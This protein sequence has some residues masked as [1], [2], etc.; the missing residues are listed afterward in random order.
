MEIIEDYVKF[1]KNNK[2]IVDAIKNDNK[3]NII[4]MHNYELISTSLEGNLYRCSHCKQ[5]CI[6]K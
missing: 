4:N 5:F 6:T 2:T 1:R 3:E